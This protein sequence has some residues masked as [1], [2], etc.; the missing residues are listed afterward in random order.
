MYILKKSFSPLA[1]AGCYID[2]KL[3]IKKQYRFQSPRGG[4]LLRTDSRNRRVCKEFQS[5]RGGGL[6]LSI[7][8]ILPNLLGFSPLAGA[9]CYLTPYCTLIT[10]YR[11][12]VPSR[13]RVVTQ[14]L[15]TCKAEKW[16]SV[17]SR[18]RVVTDDKQGSVYLKQ[19]FQ[20][21]RGGGLLLL[22]HHVY[23]YP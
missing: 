6:L 17:P 15:L 12:S 14:I 3:V 1:G 19:M 20:S 21:P 23:Q 5:P 8:W 16:V 10:T 7:R 13:G 2:E 4:G 11:V 18:G 9:G 22:P